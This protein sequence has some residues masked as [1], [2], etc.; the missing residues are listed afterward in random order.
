MSRNPLTLLKNRR[1]LMA[2]VPV[3]VILAGGYAWLSGG[4]YE[5]TNNAALHLARI[6]IASDLPGRVVSVS[7][8]DN[9]HVAAGDPLFQVDPEPYR[10]ALAQADA[11]LSQARLTVEQLKAAY[12]V[13]E[14]QVQLAKDEAEFQAVELERAQSLSGKGVSSSA[15]L[16]RARHAAAKANEA[17]ST[18]EQSLIAARAALGGDPT[19]ETDRHP[20]VLAAI[21][22]RDKAAYSLEL[23]TVRAPA[24]GVIYQAASFRAGQFV[25]AGSPV[26]VL[27][28][29]RDL[30]IDANFK[31]TQLARI[32]PGQTA[33]IEFDQQPGRKLEAVV[34]AIGAG[35]GAEFSILP[36]QNA[37]GNWV[38]VTQRV[39]VRLRLRD[40]DLAAGLQ[41]GVSAA[42]TVDTGAA[43]LRTAQADGDA[44]VTK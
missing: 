23:T 3:V 42:V 19:V 30:W 41:S 5:E 29:T 44:P 15:D 39:P 35:T 12:G 32:A 16:D 22:A 31:E 25:N 28:D 2:A 33:E 9:G 40:P 43:A 21:A 10:L 24:D 27:V 6:S 18:A 36:A 17:L 1:V 20:A 8:A 38:K 13:A 11:A 37:T 7:V 14:A 26:F 4:R 34:E